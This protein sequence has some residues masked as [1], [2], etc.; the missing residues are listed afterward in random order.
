MNRPSFTLVIVL[1]AAFCAP[2]TVLSDDDVVL[3]DSGGFADQLAYAPGELGEMSHGGG[4]W[5]P[6]GGTA[7]PGEIVALEN[8]RFDRALRRHQTGRGPTD[9]DLLDFPPAA[10]T[11][12]T[13]AFDARVST[14]DSRTLDLFLLRPGQTDARDQASILIWGYHPGKLSYFDRRPA[15]HAALRDGGGLRRADPPGPAHAPAGGRVTGEL[16]TLPHIERVQ[17]DWG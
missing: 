7:Q 11:R 3:F 12:L 6:A 15:V 5:T 2:A 9:T 14:A 4:R 1:A 8:D 16:G 13:I 17:E 10:N